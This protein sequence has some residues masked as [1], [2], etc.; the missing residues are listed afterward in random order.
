MPCIGTV[1]TW[2][3]SRRCAFATRIPG[4]FAEPTTCGPRAETVRDPPL[5]TPPI[6]KGCWFVAILALPIDE[7]SILNACTKPLTR[8]DFDEIPAAQLST[9]ICESW[10]FPVIDSY[11]SPSVEDPR[12]GANRVTFIYA[13]QGSSFPR[14]VTVVG[15]FA[16][17]YDPISLHRVQFLGADTRYWACSLV[18]PYDEVHTYKFFVDGVPTC[19]PLNPQ[20][21]RLDNNQEWSRFF[22]HYC[23]QP[24]TLTRSEAALL[25]RLTDEILPFR[26]SDG[27]RFLDRY[28]QG[29]SSSGS[30]P[31]PALYRLDEPV[32]VVNFIDNILAREERHH[33]VDYRICL[34]LID[35]V[36]RQ[37]R[38]EAA[39]CDLDGSAFVD[40]YREM[41]TD[42]V[43]GWDHGQYNSPRYFLQVLR[44][45]A[46][47]GAF[48]HPK[49]GGNVL[50]AGWAY[51]AERYTDAAGMTLF[52]WPRATEPPLGT[53][54]DYRG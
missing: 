31:G 52:D 34:R 9:T 48:S 51:L 2:A 22:T 35:R 42:R 36:L 15:T 14:A 23:T 3:M 46:F 47:T 26:T 38:P 39:P 32:G 25:Q 6:I 21:V 53:S 30:A 5:A 49:Y 29:L 24:L 33:R 7:Q 45:H 18:V 4:P 41:A 16:P 10:R 8:A 37:R 44:R 50:A 11:R 28:A 17:L 40:L 13:A 43:T 54:A 12:A 27:Q 20:R 1:P 19:D